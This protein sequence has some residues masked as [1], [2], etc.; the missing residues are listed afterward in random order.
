MS[1]PVIHRLYNDFVISDKPNRQYSLTFDGSKSNSGN[2]I[3]P[4]KNRRE[5]E[6]LLLSLGDEA[7]VIMDEQ[8]R[9]RYPDVWGWLAGRVYTEILNNLKWSYHEVEE[10][11]DIIERIPLP[12][13]LGDSF[14]KLQNDDPEPER[15]DPEYV[16]KRNKENVLISKPYTCG[17]MFYF[18]GFQ[19]SPEFIIDHGSDHL[20][21]IIIFEIARQAGI[22]STHL[23]GVPLYGTIVLIK[24]IIQYKNFVELNSSHIIC[25]I[26]VIRVRGGYFYVAFN[27]RQSDNSCAT[28]YLAGFLYKNKESYQKHR[29]LK[30]ISEASNEKI[31]K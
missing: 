11:L 22:A 10:V 20:D 15:I 25:T 6:L 16:H 28:G 1:I 27:I 29:N 9:E 24:A 31:V 12:K 17:N 4:V 18:N 3:I 7:S 30:R 14:L 23:T 8:T 19:E 21:G 5:V 26:P 13:A 2:C